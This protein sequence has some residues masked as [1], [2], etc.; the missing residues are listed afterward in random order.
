MLREETASVPKN[1]G[2]DED[3]DVSNGGEDDDDDDV[4]ARPNEW[5][6]KKVVKIKVVGIHQRN[7]FY[8]FNFFV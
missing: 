8:L 5:S 2:E 3:D 6:D 4:G 1:G 7:N